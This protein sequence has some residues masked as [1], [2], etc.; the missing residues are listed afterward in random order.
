MTLGLDPVIYIFVC[1][2]D[3]LWRILHQKK[4]RT[5]KNQELESGK[6]RKKGIDLDYAICRK[7]AGTE[8]RMDRHI[9]IPPD[10]STWQC[11]PLQAATTFMVSVWYTRSKH[12]LHRV[13]NNL[14]VSSYCCCKIYFCIAFFRRSYFILF[15][16]EGGKITCE[17]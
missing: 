3:F 1:C 17:F 16:C 5:E 8:G 14:N 9:Q 7:A 6:I 4:L 11:T 10:W 15:I 2:L 13:I 12:R